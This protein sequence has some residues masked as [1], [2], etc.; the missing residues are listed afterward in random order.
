M[1]RIRAPFLIS[2]LSQVPNAI[3]KITDVQV[4]QR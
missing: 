1:M 2:G 3:L 4:A